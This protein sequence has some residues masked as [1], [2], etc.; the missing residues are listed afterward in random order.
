M[1]H[2]KFSHIGLL[3]FLTLSFA[4]VAL[5]AK[6]DDTKHSFC[7]RVIDNFTEAG[8]GGARVVLTD[9]RGEILCTDSAYSF[10]EDDLA[11][12]PDLAD[13]AVEHG[14]VGKVERVG[15]V[16]HRVTVEK[17]LHLGGGNRQLAQVMAAQLV[18]ADW[19]QENFL[20]TV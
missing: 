3:A 17:H 9:M 12:S 14:T 20:Q 2:S 1:I 10:S 4:L 5:S 7:G 16:D 18:Q 8:I 19:W 15:I 6:A 11:F 13:E